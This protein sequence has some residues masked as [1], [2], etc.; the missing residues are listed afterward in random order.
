M[1][2]LLYKKGKYDIY[3]NMINYIDFKKIFEHINNL[4]WIKNVDDKETFEIALSAFENLKKN[5]T[6]NKKIIRIIGQ[7]GSGKTTQLL[8]ASKEYCNKKGISPIVFAV[9]NFASLHPEYDK[10]LQDYGKSNIREKTNNFALKCL[11]IN[12]IKAIEEGYDI[13]FEVTFLTKEFEDFVNKY[14]KKNGYQCLY[15]CCAVNKDISDN[16]IKKR[17][18]NKFSQECNRIVYKSSS[19]FFYKNLIKMMEYYSLNFSKETIIIWNAFDK[20][21][22]FYG[23]FRE[24]FVVFEKEIKNSSNNFQNEKELLDE[25]IKFLCGL[26]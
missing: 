10:L 4:S 6:K 23:N 19:D 20:K 5:K 15:L 24:S 11:L 18:E 9:R 13:I 22:V 25:K 8:P 21:P 2:I 3:F 1:L 14:L 26:N 12:L 16:F 7:S 17:E